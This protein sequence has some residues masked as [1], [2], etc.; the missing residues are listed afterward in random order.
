MPRKL[1][2]YGIGKFA[3]YVAYV[4]NEDSEYEVYGFCIEENLFNSENFIGKPLIKF[5]DMNKTYPPDEFEIFIA[6]GNNDVRRRI[7]NGA[8]QLE[9]NI[10]TYVSTKCRKWDNLKVGINCFID[11]GCVLQPFINI[12]DN[13]ILFTTDLGHHTTICSDSLLSGSKTGGNVRVG[14]Y[15]Y[16]GLNASVKQNVNI[17]RR[18]IIGMNCSIEKDTK[19]NSVYSHKGTVKRSIDATVLGNRFLQ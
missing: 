19:E 1:I 9:Y 15:S 8:L 3:E 4:F 5:Q 14:S 11:E 12:E 18:N 17:A 7:L 13:C 6:V 2:I 16:I 10:A